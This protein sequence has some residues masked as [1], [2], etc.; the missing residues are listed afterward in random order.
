MSPLIS[1]PL[2]L[3]LSIYTS[4]ISPAEGPIMKP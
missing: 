1:L 2:S 4:D 3:P